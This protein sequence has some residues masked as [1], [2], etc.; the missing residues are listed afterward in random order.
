MTAN[1]D[2]RRR[3][4]TKSERRD[5]A[6]KALEMRRNGQPFDV[7]AEELGITVKRASVYVND[8]L[9][10]RSVEGVDQYRATVEER[11]DDL[12]RQLREMLENL[13]I[14][15]SQKLTALQQ[16]ASIE[17]KRVRLLGLAVPIKQVIELQK[18]SIWEDG[19]VE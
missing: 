4:R 15:T 13:D 17:E 7:I 10:E 1:S 5:L 6:L 16:L 12:T 18:E 14:T 2:G 11:Y 3:R 8:L 19:Y 9:K